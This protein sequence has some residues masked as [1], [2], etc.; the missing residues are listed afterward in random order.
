MFA[1]IFLNTTGN[2][3]ILPADE[4]PLARGILERFSPKLFPDSEA[5]FRRRSPYLDLTTF[6]PGRITSDLLNAQA[7]VSPLPGPVHLRRNGSSCSQLP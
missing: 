2:N 1:T 4:L 3:P 6:M 5:G 7:W